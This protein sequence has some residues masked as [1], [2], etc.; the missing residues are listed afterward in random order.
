MSRR[1][2]A[3]AVTVAVIIVGAALIGDGGAAV[4]N[5]R[6]ERP[7]A[8]NRTDVRE[9]PSETP[10]TVRGCAIRF[11]RR[12]PAGRTRPRVHANSTHYCLGVT[13]V[14]A[15]Y[16]SGDLIIETDSEGPII[17]V[18]V[19]PDETLTARGIDCGASGGIRITRIRCHDRDGDQVK[20]YSRE[21][22]GPGANLWIGWVSWND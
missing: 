6:S 9:A 19:S 20:A 7:I 15:E 18:S 8:A 13:E 1:I 21:I 11:D 22:Y 14:R 16:P 3:V 17:F 10:I 5:T 4:P 2:A 12:D